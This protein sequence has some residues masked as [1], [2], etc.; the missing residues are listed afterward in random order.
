MGQFQ[1]A[2]RQSEHRS[3]IATRPARIHNDELPTIA[4]LENHVHA[5]RARIMEGDIRG[6]G[7]QRGPQSLNNRDTHSVIASVQV[8]ASH[9]H[10]HD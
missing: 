2:A 7:I 10:A 6:Q 1:L 5:G 3:R 9:H 4:G 8:A